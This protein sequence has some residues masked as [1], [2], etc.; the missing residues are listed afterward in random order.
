MF[1]ASP[2]NKRDEKD[3]KTW[4]L[5]KPAIHVL[6]ESELWS[7]YSI[8]G[9]LYSAGCPK[10]KQKIAVAYFENFNSHFLTYL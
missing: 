6:L 10:K 1:E 7:D 8:E 2:A 9:I 4:V 3:L 5:G